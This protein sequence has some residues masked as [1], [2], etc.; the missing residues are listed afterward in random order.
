MPHN[1][2]SLIDCQELQFEATK[3][4]TD[5]AHPTFNKKYSKKRSNKKI[6]LGYFSADFRTHPVGLLTAELF[7]LHNKDRFEIFAFSSMK[8]QDEDPIRARD[9]KSFDHFID[10]ESMSD[11]EI[12]MLANDLEIDIAIDLGGHTQNA[13]IDAFACRVAPIQVNYLGYAGTIGADFYDYLIADKLVIPEENQQFFTEKIVYMPDT[14]M[15]DDSTR[16]PSSSTEFSSLNLPSN[17]VIYTC[18]NNGYKINENILGSWVRILLNVEN[19]ILWLSE[20]NTFLDN[21]ILAELTKKGVA[22]DRVFFAKKMQ[23]MSDHL[24][25]L[26][27]ADI[28]LDTFPYN[29]HTTAIDSLKV[30]VPLITCLSKSFPGRVAS[31]L[32]SAIGLEELITQSISEYEEL[33]ISLGK[34]PKRLLQIKQKLKTN[35]HEKPLFNT[36]LFVKNLEAGY[37][38]MMV[39]HNEGCPINHIYV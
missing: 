22:A 15:V 28:F 20:N 21:S 39:A 36:K 4:F 7:E 32:L 25:R 38:K 33:A 1:L 24:A 5:F 23:L 34:D 12:S 37:E 14:F 30:G 35:Y 26:T 16:Q 31:S 19:S 11:K 2:L 3:L 6:K 27:F 29:A 10:I 8:C 13:R 18:F 17:K 9:L